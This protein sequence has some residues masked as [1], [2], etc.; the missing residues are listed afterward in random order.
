MKIRDEWFFQK[1]VERLFVRF[2]GD[3][4]DLVTVFEQRDS[5]VEA[6]YSFCLPIPVSR[7]QMTFSDPFN[8]PS[9]S[10]DCAC[11][12]VKLVRE[13]GRHFLSRAFRN[14]IENLELCR[15]RPHLDSYIDSSTKQTVAQREWQE[16]RTQHSKRILISRSLLDR[17]LS[18][19]HQ[20]LLWC[21]SS[22]RFTERRLEE[23]G[24][25]PYRECVRHE[26]GLYVRTANPI[27]CEGKIRLP[28]MESASRVVGKRH[29][30]MSSPTA[31]QSMRGRNP[32]APNFEVR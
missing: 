20:V 12:R 21:V 4:N 27:T 30:C 24:V 22:V 1:D 2:E 28:R 18:H 7:L 32:T 11:L 25:T 13:I 23:F 16:D 26:D 15:M 3:E 9:W 6:F 8:D 17:F 29:V 19:T 14:R 5:Y 10:A 31:C